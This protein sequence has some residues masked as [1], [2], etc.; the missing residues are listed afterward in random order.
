MN[1]SSIIFSLGIGRANFKSIFTFSPTHLPRIQINVV[2]GFII[3]RYWSKSIIRSSLPCPRISGR[4][5]DLVEKV[6]N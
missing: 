6:S 5:G 1:L 3:S 2:M 4:S